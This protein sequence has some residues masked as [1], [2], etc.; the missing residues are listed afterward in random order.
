MF[1]IAIVQE[2][3]DRRRRCERPCGSDD[4]RVFFPMIAVA[5]NAGT[6]SEGHATVKLGSR[7]SSATAVVSDCVS[8]DGGSFDVPTKK[9]IPMRANLVS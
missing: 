3:M 8:T 2:E 1:A 6:A 4:M 9:C 5:T 7:I